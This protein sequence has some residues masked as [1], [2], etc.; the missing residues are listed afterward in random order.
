MLYNS[1]HNKWLRLCTA[2]FGTLVMCFAQAFF[3]VPL[4]LYT[5]G[6]MGYC[7]FF[8]T[9][10]QDFAG[11]SFGSTDIAGI[12]YFLFNIP[13]LLLSF[14]YLGRPLTVKTVI[15]VASYTL[16][17]SAIPAPESALVDDYLT[18]CLLGGILN[19]IGSGLVLTCGCS[20][21][22]LDIL[23]LIL[24]KRGSS[25]TVGRFSIGFNAALYGLCLWLFVP[26]VAIYSLIYNV[27]SNLALDRVHQQNV[28][29][30]AL[31]FTKEDEQKL[32][33]FIME[34]LHR[35]VTYWEG[36]GAYTGGAIHVLC[37][38]LSKYEI[39]ELLHVVRGIDPHAFITV[40]K[41]VQIYGNY[42]RK[43]E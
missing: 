29:M 13:I 15:C 26:E 9:L 12:L 23:G 27:T 31:I 14:R 30:Q 6:L 25:F 10:L 5:G 16:F 28:N 7:Q 11:F 1:L 34:N 43:V 35:G 19:G 17:Y 21:G 4:R 3:I 22:G 20:T 32:G 37:V 2:V 33:R 36:T 24:S 42:H 41:G 39:E 8:R 40:Q 38:S 18:G